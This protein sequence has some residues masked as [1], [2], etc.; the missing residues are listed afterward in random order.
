M[1]PIRIISGG[2]TG[3][4]QAALDA[5]LVCGVECGGWCPAGRLAEGGVIP[6]RY[7]MKELPKGGYL[8]RTK[9]N[10][11]DADGTVIFYFGALEGGTEQT[12]FHCIKSRRP[13]KL[14]DGSEIPI[15]RAAELLDEFVSGQNIVAL[16]VAGPR[17]SKSPRAYKYAYTV[18][19]RFLRRCQAEA[20]K[21]SRK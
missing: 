12:V 7:P 17:A 5:A 15:D 11:N 18:L 9:Q 6:D 13:Y 10:I 20:H 19:C 8:Q 14:I 21:P 4:D 1:T 2:Q 16:N 3:V